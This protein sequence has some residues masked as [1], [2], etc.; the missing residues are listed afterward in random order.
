MAVFGLCI[1]ESE[2]LPVLP[3]H[4]YL[5]DADAPNTLSWM[6]SHLLV[7]QLCDDCEV[8]VADPDGDGLGVIC[9]GDKAA[10]YGDDEGYFMDH[11]PMDSDPWD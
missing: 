6:R 7:V 9:M 2:I 11:G 5:F 10:M 8:E 1:I 4:D 3:A